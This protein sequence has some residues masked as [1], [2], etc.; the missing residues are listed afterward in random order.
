MTAS[1]IQE[2]Y[3][4]DFHTKLLTAHKIYQDKGEALCSIPL[5]RQ[6]LVALE[7]QAQRLQEQVTALNFGLLCSSCALKSGGGCCSVYMA[8]ENDTVLLLINLLAG[9]LVSIQKDDDFECYLLGPMGCILR[10]KPIFCLNYNCH[11]INRR[12]PPL[13]RPIFIKVK[14]EPF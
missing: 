6:G 10:F 4:S 13:S 2:L 12:V 8:D 14:V 9:S 11:A 1:L 3:H 7:R 5:V